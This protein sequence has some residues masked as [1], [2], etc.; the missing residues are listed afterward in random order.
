[1][2]QFF[3]KLAKLVEFALEKQKFPK[4]SQSFFVEKATHFVGGK[5]NHQSTNHHITEASCVFSLVDLM[6][7]WQEQIVLKKST[8]KLIFEPSVIQAFLSLS[9]SLKPRVQIV[10]HLIETK[11]IN[12]EAFCQNLIVQL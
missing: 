6:I 7:S 9:I 1:M 10:K 5:K 11:S 8:T 3:Q 4:F 12:C 2:L